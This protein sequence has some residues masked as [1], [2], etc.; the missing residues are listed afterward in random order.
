MAAPLQQRFEKKFQV[1]PGCWLWTGALGGGAGDGRYGHIRHEGKTLPA[2]RVSYELHKGEVPQGIC[3]CHKCDNPRCVNPEHLFLGTHLDNMRD[4]Y[5][6]GRRVAATGLRSGPGKLSDDQKAD[7][8]KSN[9]TTQ[10]LA[11]AHGVS[12]VRINQLRRAARHQAQG[13]MNHG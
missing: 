13:A 5:S 12:T 6:K 8:V 10:E 2:H 7:I 3:V 11:L 1:T 4:M 9:Q